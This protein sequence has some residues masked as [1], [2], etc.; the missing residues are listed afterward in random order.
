MHLEEQKG[1]KSVEMKVGEMV[2]S[3]VYAL[4]VGRV[5]LT[6]FG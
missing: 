4:V 2:A 1:M 5:A 6:A 3:M